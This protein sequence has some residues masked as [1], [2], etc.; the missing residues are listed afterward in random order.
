M[1]T[2]DLERRTEAAL[3]IRQVLVLMVVPMVLLAGLAAFL[4]TRHHDPSFGDVA[5]TCTAPDARGFVTVADDGHTLIVEAP[6]RGVGSVASAASLCVLQQ[7]HAP[8][9]ILAKIG[10]TT[11][12]QGQVHDAWKGYR[13]TWTYHPSSGVGIIVER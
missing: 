11:A 6:D 13:V 4:L 3:K 1:V 9:S 10:E 7:L 2:H 8:A 12:I 5:T